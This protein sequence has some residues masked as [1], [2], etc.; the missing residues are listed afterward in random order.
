MKIIIALI[1][2]FIICS[3]V[4][5]KQDKV[6]YE[7]LYSKAVDELFRFSQTDD[8]LWLLNAECY[9]DSINC[10]PVKHKIFLT[11]I[12]LYYQLKR[13]EDGKRYV[14]SFDISDFDREYQRDMYLNFFEALEYE[15][16]GDSIMR[17]KLY[18][19]MIADVQLYLD[20]NDDQ[21]ALLDLFSIKSKIETCEQIVQEIQLLKTSGKYD[22]EFFDMM[23]LMMTDT[24]SNEAKSI[25][26]PVK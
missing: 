13:Y 17:N 2:L 10:K 5:K 23:M 4:E 15:N 19:G 25:V 8:T 9:L 26:V 3:C 24:D 12:G 18:R 1:L 7:N 14:L 22:S 6:R 11:K 16:E 21:E 20:R